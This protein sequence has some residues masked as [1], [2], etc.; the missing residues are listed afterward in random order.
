MDIENDFE[1][2][3]FST[4]YGNMHYKHHKG[5][6][7]TIIFLHG[8]A[9]SV[10]SW[11]RLVNYLPSS[12][13]IYL[14]DLLGHGQSDAPDIDY[15][16][17][18]HYEALLKFIRNNIDAAPFLFGHSY[19][20]WLAAYYSSINTVKGLILEDSAGLREFIDERHQSNPEYREAMI[21]DALALNPREH[22][23][24]SMLHAD[25]SKT[26]LDSKALAKIDCKC[27]IIWGSEDATVGLKY[28]DQFNKEIKGSSLQIIVGAKHTP[29]YSRPEEVARILINFI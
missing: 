19:G 5:S 17:H 18:M 21:K 1:D 12:L 26:Q 7:Q 4:K 29:H 16:L 11:T 9:A 28:S 25:N 24:R 13:D 22:V 14:I 6:A 15:T 2:S 27:L 23:L 8:F 20:G 3:Y 10:K